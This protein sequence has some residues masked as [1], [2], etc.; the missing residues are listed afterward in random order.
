MKI[1]VFI[2]SN[3]CKGKPVFYKFN[4]LPNQLT[5]LSSMTSIKVDFNNFY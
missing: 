5:L 3:V 4:K 2:P 1:V